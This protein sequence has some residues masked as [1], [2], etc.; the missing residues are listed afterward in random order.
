MGASFFIWLAVFLLLLVILALPKFRAGVPFSLRVF[1]AIAP[2]RRNRPG[3]LCN[4]KPGG[5]GGT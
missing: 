2:W 3:D 1:I 4:S 5:I